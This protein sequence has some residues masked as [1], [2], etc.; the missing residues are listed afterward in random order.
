MTPRHSVCG[1]AVD[2]LRSC[3]SSEW[4]LGD[5]STILT[6]GRYVFAPENQPFYPG[7][8]CFWARIWTTDDWG[9]SPPQ[10]GESLSALQRWYN[11]ATPEVFPNAV[12]IHAPTDPEECGGA[13]DGFSK[14]ITEEEG[15]ASWTIDAQAARIDFQ[16]SLNCGGT[17]DNRQKGQ[18]TLHVATSIQRQV[19]LDLTGLVERQNEFFDLG[20]V[21][22]DGVLAA[23]LW[24]K[25]EHLGCTMLAV[26]ASA[27]VDIGPGNHTITFTGDTIDNLYHVGAFFQ[28]AVDVDPPFDPPPEYWQGFPV[29]CYL[30]ASP[31]PPAPRFLPPDIHD[32]K[33]WLAWAEIMK[34]LYV[35]PASA[36]AL[37]QAKLGPDAGVTFTNH[38]NNVLPN[39]IVG[40]LNDFTVCVIEGTSNEFQ[41]ADYVCT[42]ITG[43]IPIAGGMS[44]G[45]WVFASDFFLNFID[46]ALPNP[47][48][49][50]LVIGHSYGGAIAALLAARFRYAQPN[51]LIDVLTY[52]SAQPGDADIALL[53]ESCNHRRVTCF[54]DPVPEMPPNPI[55]WPWVIPLIPFPVAQAW[56]FYF[57]PRG[58]A[59]IAVDGT[60]TFSEE[61]SFDLDY[62]RQAVNAYLFGDAMVSDFAHTMVETVRR[63][64]LT[65]ER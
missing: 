51:R 26:A 12:Q 31:F 5:D 8:H 50:I 40:V 53:V 6:P 32:P 11:G 44:N 36:A 14:W 4:R 27:Q 37:V 60:Y 48:G 59:L 25:G 1:Y 23:S 16:D 18:A 22:V 35:S 61:T 58:Q 42:T 47:T 55:H 30:P 10:M 20:E 21:Y 3:Y 65:V 41:V 15:G 39:C 43:Q 54:G 19:V 52:G 45:T 29:Q 7:F 64:R 46:A 38:V 62:L 57:Q 17:N 33:E 63:L 28:L 24:G 13:I 2:W 9:D 34:E 56:G 49:R